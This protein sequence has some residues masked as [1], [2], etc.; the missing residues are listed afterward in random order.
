MSR[1]WTKEDLQRQAVAAK[2]IL[3]ELAESIDGDEDAAHDVVEGETDFFEACQRV[4][5]E[6]VACEVIVAGC[7]DTIGTLTKRKSRA[8]VRFGRLKGMLDQ[9]FQM[10]EVPKHQF[11]TA[12]VSTKKVPPKLIVSEES[13][14]PARFFVTPAPVLDKKAL[15]DAL[16]A[17]EVIPGASLSNGGVTIQ[18]RRA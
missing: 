10:A 12:T 2:S 1:D 16:K 8:E 3:A 13:E 9:A 4:L 5:D 14:I 18:I 17:K 6:M 11:P 7:K 15:L